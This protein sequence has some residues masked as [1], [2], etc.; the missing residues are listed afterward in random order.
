MNS[1]DTL[2]LL[3]KTQQEEIKKGKQY[4]LALQQDI[5]ITFMTKLN[6]AGLLW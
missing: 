1:E 6:E 2:K 5:E 3:R 4:L